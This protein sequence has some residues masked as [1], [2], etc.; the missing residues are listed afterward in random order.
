MAAAEPR[1]EALGSG[2][3]VY[4]AQMPEVAGAPVNE[5]WF[6]CLLE[7]LTIIKRK[8]SSSWMT[9]SVLGNHKASLLPRLLA[10]WVIALPLMLF[11]LMLV[12]AIFSLTVGAVTGGTYVA[13]GGGLVTFQN[14]YRAMGEWA[15]D[16]DT[17]QAAWDIAAMVL[18]LVL[19]ILVYAVRLMQE[20]WNGFCPALAMFVDIIYEMG[21]QLVMIW[22][23]SPLLQYVFFFF[24][25]LLVFL[26]E[27]FFDAISTVFEAFADVA[28]ELASDLNGNASN[29][30]S[31]LGIEEGIEDMS[32]MAGDLILYI[33]VVIGTLLI[34]LT[35]ALIVCFLPL[36]YAFLRMVL[37][38]ILKYM[39]PLLEIA[40][41]FGSI[42]AS[43]PVKRLLDFLFQA[44]PIVLELMQAFVCAI[45][46]YLGA[47]ACYALYVICVSI[48][49]IMRY[50]IRP[51]VC[52]SN[53]ILGGC[54][55]SFVASAISGKTCFSCGHYNTACGCKAHSQ[56]LDNDC[57]KDKCVDPFDGTSTPAV[58]TRAPPP[59]STRGNR[60]TSLPPQ[61]SAW[62]ASPEEDAS[63]FNDR[64]ATEGAPPGGSIQL[65]LARSGE[66]WGQ[67]DYDVDPSCGNA[68]LSTTE[69]HTVRQVELPLNLHPHAS[70]ATAPAGHQPSPTP[71]PSPL[72]P[73]PGPTI[74]KVQAEGATVHVSKGA[75]AT[76][77]AG[78]YASVMVDFVNYDVDP[79]RSSAAGTY[80]VWGTQTYTLPPPVGGGAATQC[81]PFTGSSCDM[82]T[83]VASLSDSLRE[84]PQAGLSPGAAWRSSGWGRAAW[85]Q[86][87]FSQ[88]SVVS[89]VTLEW[90][91]DRA[92]GGV[93]GP[94][95]YT[96]A[97]LGDT[98][99]FDVRQ[100]CRVDSPYRLDTVDAVSVVAVDGVRA[101]FEAV[102]VCR[103]TPAEKHA[104]PLQLARLN[105][106]GPAVS[107]PGAGTGHRVNW[108]ANATVFGETK[109]AAETTGV[110][111][112]DPC[113]R[114]STVGLHD[115]SHWPPTVFVVTAENPTLVLDVQMTREASTGVLY[116]PR[117]HVDRV[118]V[119]LAATAAVDPR[120]VTLCPVGAIPGN[121]SCVNASLTSS[122][123]T[124]EGYTQ[125]ARDVL[126]THFGNGSMYDAIFW[127]SQAA[128]SRGASLEFEG[129]AI[130]PGGVMRLW[131]HGGWHAGL[132]ATQWETAAVEL[133]VTSSHHIEGQWFQQLEDDLGADGVVSTG[134]PPAGRCT[135]YATAHATPHA[136]MYKDPFAGS[137]LPWV[138]IT[139]ID[140][141][142]DYPTDVGSVLSLQQRRLLATQSVPTASGLR[143]TP[144]SAMQRTLR[145]R[146]LSR[147]GSGVASQFSV[148][149]VMASR[150]VHQFGTGALGGQ[151][152]SET[153]NTI[154]RYQTR[155]V[156]SSG[157]QPYA[158]NL[159]RMPDP[160]H[161]TTFSCARYGQPPRIK[162][163]ERKRLA[164][165][166]P[167]NPGTGGTG[168]STAGPE[169]GA[170]MAHTSMGLQ[171]VPPPVQLQMNKIGDVVQ[172]RQYL[173]RLRL[174]EMLNSV[175]GVTTTAARPPPATRP[176]PGRSLLGSAAEATWNT[177]KGPALDLI[178]SVWETTEG[179]ITSAMQCGEYCEAATGCNDDGKLGDC[180]I[181]AIEFVVAKIFQCGADE[182][183]YDCTIGKLFDLLAEGLLQ[184]LDFILET[185]DHVG[186]QVANIMGLGDML[187][188]IGCQSCALATIL[189]GLLADFADNFP[190][191]ICLMIMEKGSAQCEHWGLGDLG[192]QGAA[193]FGN[194]LPALKLLFGII[195]VLPAL[196]EV[197]LEFY[198]L[199]FTELLEIFPDLLNDA[200]DIILW[201]VASSDVVDTMET[202][203]S[204]IDPLLAEVQSQAEK[205]GA[206][207]GASS[208]SDVTDQA[209]STPH[210]P[211]VGF[212]FHGE[213]DTGHGECRQLQNQP[214]VPCDDGSGT[215]VDVNLATSEAEATAKVD[216]D[217]AR[218]AGQEEP[219]ITMG[220]PLRSCG[221]KVKP[222]TCS[223]GA[224][225]GNCPMSVG[226]VQR[227]AEQRRDAVNAMR[228]D[229]PPDDRDQWQHCANVN[230]RIIVPPQSS[231]PGV[232][233]STLKK[234]YQDDKRCFITVRVDKNGNMINPAA[235]EDAVKAKTGRP[236]SW[237][238]F[239]QFSKQDGSVNRDTDEDSDV[240]HFKPSFHPH[241]DSIHRRRASAP[242]RRLLTHSSE[243]PNLMGVAFLFPELQSP[244]EATERTEE[245]KSK[246]QSQNRSLA[247]EQYMALMHDVRAMDR[248]VR[249]AARN[250][251]ASLPEQTVAA[252]ALSGLQHH[253][254][255][256]MGFS[257]VEVEDVACGFTAIPGQS[258]STYPCCKGLW[259]CTKPLIP[260]AFRVQKEWFK[261]R[262][263]WVVDTRCPHTSS[264]LDVYLFTMRA[265]FKTARSAATVVVKVWPYTT[266]VD[267]IWGAF[268]FPGDEWPPFAGLCFSLNIGAFV[269]PL[270]LL[271]C[272]YL[273][274]PTVT[275]WV[276]AHY[277]IF[278]D[279]LTRSPYEKLEE[280]FLAGRFR[281]DEDELLD[282][283]EEK[284]ASN[285]DSRK[286]ERRRLLERS[287]P[288]AVRNTDQMFEL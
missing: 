7:E 31:T 275:C 108:R 227:K 42:F 177:I 59:P 6:A 238:K 181:G 213:V 120:G 172:Q 156:A 72:P 21:K 218:H 279:C 153:Q 28:A 53:A 136:L 211:P 252:A 148:A 144:D 3:I 271:L 75:V 112:W 10:L 127:D 163:G 207:T 68:Q 50:V 167:P 48:G 54:L 38:K 216:Q 149:Q 194:L 178:N 78:F 142:G 280:S 23:S 232:A 52:A 2:I 117:V 267:T 225:T 41:K 147:G 61:R 262:D 35:E 132:R 12:L 39:P 179:L 255:R 288:P 150:G 260:R 286:N 281:P 11:R 235:L 69:T 249:E 282:F 159:H 191:S 240:G 25:R 18:A 214:E 265:I 143:D 106:F 77:S 44:L 4:K 277:N 84:T 188:I 184:L 126:K 193:V 206:T 192:S 190:L 80:L 64:S 89:Q 63:R 175:D 228:A 91:V 283:S 254:R 236:S 138:G 189:T 104:A 114:G 200:F 268:Q 58:D 60:T 16:N 244:S 226:S 152:K 209:A 168:A 222:Q 94:E 57:T 173:R 15:M 135:H 221:C 139:E 169:V 284:T 133:G 20:V 128:P 273:T 202:L 26:S 253:A 182:S 56:P 229:A 24:V 251:S 196:M 67:C 46:T 176:P 241:L 217:A 141:F 27:P 261:W 37:P 256:L 234:M 134:P 121:A 83:V 287:K 40:A 210:T 97:T 266:L 219:D 33:L 43:E 105:V 90:V 183:I 124:L 71:A 162:C 55:K 19:N 264:Y 151:H 8:L 215:R 245:L 107:A 170:D 99:S 125:A 204:T 208:F 122:S 113:A 258:P 92:T 14:Y 30:R 34:R 161:D 32:M 199:M 123:N 49:F 248:L 155:G 36:T 230:E 82:N 17:F 98:N 86:L 101:D 174:E 185:I 29:G 137:T 157:S 96:I 22:F 259:C 1:G 51:T 85:Y 93:H 118:I 198:L 166:A 47:V 257:G 285:E 9:F 247:E 131:F 223:E 237:W 5:A 115:G 145:Q 130:P 220:L 195:Q 88:S 65:S 129:I 13:V 81:P 180:V 66:A 186:T 165:E 95:H 103:V 87:R 205:V 263:S 158:P 154:Y 242:G 187:K 171:A 243:A 70:A 79:E 111:V 100:P 102:G 197:I 278:D 74:T 164:L 146:R 233:P 274:A 239:R 110:G 109:V 140:V 231:L 73:A 212:Q 246:L 62:V 250:F 119:H 201:F 272:A 160:R 116:H 269:I 203:F 45:V 276:L 224:G 76:A 270:L